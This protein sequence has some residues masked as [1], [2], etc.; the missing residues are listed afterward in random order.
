[1]KKRFEHLKETLSHLPAYPGVYMMKDERGSILYIGKAKSLR[2][3][4]RSYFQEKAAHSPRI[5]VMVGKVDKI[6]MIV[7][8]SEMEA[9]I[10]ED[11]LI[12]K[13]APRYN[14]ML[15][16]D[17]NYPYLKITA[18]EKFPRLVLVRKVLKDGSIYFGPYVST[19]SVRITMRLIHKI[20][21]IRQSK[22]ALDGKPHRRP[23]LNHQ[24]GRCLAPCAG[25]V[26]E[27]EYREVVDQVVM[28]L[29][30]RNEKLIKTLHDKMIEASGA[31]IYELAARYRD[32]I[33]AVTR[34]NERQTITDTGLADE[35]VIATFAQ[36]G[37]MIIK[38]FQI[39]G[40]KLNAERYYRFD[41]L[42]LADR[43]EALAAFI[44]QFYTGAM[45]IPGTIVAQDEP[46]SRT[47]LEDLLTARRSKRVRIIVPRRGRKKKLVDMAEANAKLQHS[48]ETKAAT[49][50][51]EAVDEIKN[52]F[53]LSERP[54]TIEAYDISNT[55]GTSSVGAVVVFRDGAPSRA[56]YRKYRIKSVAGT[57]D[58]ASIAE[59]VERR[60]R[61]MA[62][63][64]EP[65][66]DLILIDGG[67]GQLKIVRKKFD[68][69]G[70][71]APPLVGIAKGMDRENPESDEFY[72]P[73]R[74]SP[75]SLPPSSP[76]RF[77]LQRARDEAHRFAV[78]YHKKLRDKDVIR[79]SLDSIPGVGPKR[80]KA[81]LQH[82][83]SVKKIREATVEQ[84]S[85]AL[86]VSE[87][88]ARSIYE[89][90]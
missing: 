11:N 87:K 20:F 69:L 56:D 73:G 78:S 45:T 79:S 1:M 6:D 81:L 54:M 49:G 9:L 4:V 30:G 2:N 44:R 90:L 46:D 63:N 86:R 51:E 25:Y 15:R 85:G 14:V 18:F 72:L 83:G 47:A 37:R 7:T 28:F 53:D 40:G 84:I 41:K 24:M 34:I 65:F 75:V 21:P 59:V 80:K 74:P 13:E 36:D 32:Q 70:L 10:L 58:Y 16:D 39:R 3:R 55:S 57:D 82:F 12:K 48:A 5:T 89:N 62:R 17:K 31:M 26:T 22:D 33:E 35:D 52:A 38:I 68:E 88:V 42:D 61:R 43:A 29:R 23:C 27:R 66:P 71:V 8:S 60:Y 77:L 67:K 76:G 19:K 64:K 50:V